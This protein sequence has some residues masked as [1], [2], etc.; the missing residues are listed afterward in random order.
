DN[1]AE[2]IKWPVVGARGETVSAAAAAG[3]NIKVVTT[4]GDSKLVGLRIDKGM[5]TRTY[6]AQETKAYF[7]QNLSDIDR[8]FTV[9]HVVR[10]GWVRLDDKGDPHVGPEAFRFK[11]QAARGKTGQQAVRE[12]RTFKED[13]HALKNFTEAYLRFLLASPAAS[14]DVKAALTKALA[15]QAKIDETHKQIGELDKQLTILSADHTRVRENLKIIPMSSEHY[16]TFLEKFV[17]QDKQIES[18]QKNMR[19]LGATM[20][21]QMRDYDQWA[22]KLDAE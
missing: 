8:T 14:A 3:I 10:P 9:D 4:S 6:Q 7:V 21:A 11:I 15:T 20:Q 12:Q 18:L 1:L 22:A 5:I 16:K 2:Q 13:A 19:D 17:A